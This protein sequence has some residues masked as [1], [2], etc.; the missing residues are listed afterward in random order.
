MS[1]TFNYIAFGNRAYI[2][3]DEAGTGMRRGRILEYTPTEI[4]KRLAALDERASTYL[5]SL[6][7]FLA[8]EISASGQGYSML[9]KYGKVAN[10]SVDRSSVHADFLGSADFGEIGFDNIEDAQ[11][12]FGADRYELYRTHS[13]VRKGDAQ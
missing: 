4:E 12:L 1:E 11:S 7:T 6:P 10:L 2:K 5:E 8:S 9:V 3:G 13:A